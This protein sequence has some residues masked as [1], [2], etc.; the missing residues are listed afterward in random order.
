[1]IALVIPTYGG[2]PVL[3]AVGPEGYK[4]IWGLT[5]LIAPLIIYLVWEKIPW[6]HLSKGKPGQRSGNP[7]FSVS[8]TGEPEFRPIVL[9]LRITND[10]DRTIDVKAPVIV[11][12]RWRS[13]R[14]FRI[15]KVNESEIYPLLLDP[16]HSHELTIH[17][18]P[19]YRKNA[20][21]RTA[22]RV[23]VEVGEVNKKARKIS[24]H[25]RLKWI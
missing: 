14:R 23:Q 17:L 22:T 25:V 24:G 3:H 12:R 2:L 20:R 1:M 11:F 7:G 5:V 21:L 6:Q 8:L 15:R 4:M 9:Y 19:F 13:S 10:S 18:E 16:G